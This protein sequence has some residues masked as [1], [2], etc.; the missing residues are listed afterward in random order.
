[1]YTHNGLFAVCGYVLD[2][3]GLE[4]L[5]PDWRAMLTLYHIP[6][7]HMTECN[8][9]S[10]VF[11]HLSA[12]ECDLCAREAIRIAR[13]YPLHGRAFVL[14]QQDYRDILQDRGFDCDP[15]TFMVWSAFVQVN[16]WVRKNKPDHKMSLFFEDG[17]LTEKRSNE[18]L[19]AFSKEPWN[20]KNRI[21]SYG[22]VKKVDS[23][24]AQ[25]ADLVSWHV[26][27]S[28]QNR[29]DKKPYRADSK[30]LFENKSILTISWTPELLKN[31][32]NEFIKL[33]GSLEEASKSLFV[34][35][36]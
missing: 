17:W 4:K 35:A 14:D 15:Y 6:Y 3:N 23:E 31:I 19:A 16:T 2:I 5:I 36:E 28:Y 27:K 20:G 9:N 22:F 26:R 10:G 30:A 8:S 11:K 12:K 7:F 24:A 1:M 29:R 18:L 21:A 34:S 33:R 13:A 32:G 25:A